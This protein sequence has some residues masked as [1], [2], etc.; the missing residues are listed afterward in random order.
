MNMSAS[1]ELLFK[2]IHIVSV[3]KYK[4]SLACLLLGILKDSNS[5]L[6]FGEAVDHS[7]IHNWEMRLRKIGILEKTLRMDRYCCV[8]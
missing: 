7:V 1:D 6:L 4:W 8:G 3:S 5:L 2:Y